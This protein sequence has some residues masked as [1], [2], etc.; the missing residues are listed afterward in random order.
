V[1]LKAP[2][3]DSERALWDLGDPEEARRFDAGIEIVSLVCK[4]RTE[5]EL[6]DS[7]KHECTPAACAVR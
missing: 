5:R 3:V 4:A 7:Y 1:K 2:A 6:I